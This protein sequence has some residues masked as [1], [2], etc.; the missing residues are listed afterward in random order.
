MLKKLN[1]LFLFIYAFNI[2]S[3]AVEF[4]QLDSWLGAVKNGNV[5]LILEH[6]N[7]NIDI[8]SYDPITG[9][10]ALITAIENRDFDTVKLLVSVGADI[11][12]VTQ[13]NGKKACALDSALKNLEIL[14]FLVDCGADVTVQ[15]NYKRTPLHNAS[16]YFSSLAI[17]LKNGNVDVNVKDL[18]GVTPLHS[19][20]YDYD[21]A[22]LL[23]DLGADLFAKDQDGWKPLHRAY[24]HRNLSVMKELARRGAPFDEFTPD[25]NN[26]LHYACSRLNPSSFDLIKFLVETHNM[27]LNKNALSSTNGRPGA[28]TPFMNAVYSQLGLEDNFEILDY[29][30]DKGADLYAKFYIDH[31]SHIS[32]LFH[33]VREWAAHV[34]V[35]RYILEW[36]KEKENRLPN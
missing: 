7:Q 1:I 28:T 21:A 11:D 32:I 35:K 14:E 26:A 10:S 13:A 18:F 34:K 25:G 2:N 24:T 33:S 5:K 8:D 6:L 23:L 17:L 31:G 29:L 9:K 19:G 36:L 4:E 27:D 20:I 22:I 16:Q 3:Y 15:L 12:L 30:L